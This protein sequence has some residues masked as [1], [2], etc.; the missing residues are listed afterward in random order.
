M[1]ELTQK[2]YLSIPPEIAYSYVDDELVLMD[3]DEHV[4]YGV[5]SVGAAIW[6]FLEQRPASLHA[7]CEHLQQIYD[8]GGAQ[9]REDATAFIQKMLSHQMLAITES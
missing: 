9:C 4:Y 5:N 7:I 6:N 8:V 3:V 1:I 2:S